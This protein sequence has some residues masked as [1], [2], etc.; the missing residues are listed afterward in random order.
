MNR[1][2][3]AGVSSIATAKDEASATLTVIGRAP[4]NSPVVPLRNTRG[5][6]DAMMVAVAASTGTTRSEAERG[7][8]S[9]GESP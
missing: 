1:R 8:A 6:N 9:A 4:M 7:A 3:S 2:Q 5:K